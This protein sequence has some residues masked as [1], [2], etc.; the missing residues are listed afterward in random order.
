MIEN[1]VD[2]EYVPEDVMYE[3]CAEYL[4]NFLDSMV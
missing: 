1:E 2:W 4:E 3:I